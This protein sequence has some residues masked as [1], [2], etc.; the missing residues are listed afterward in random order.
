MTEKSRS[1]RTSG[2]DAH[3]LQPVERTRLADRAHAALRQSIISGVFPMGE[4]LIETQLA[5]QLNMSRA[6]I[7]EALRGL[8]QEGLVVEHPHQGAFVATL[9][10]EDVTDLYN[11]RI[12]IETTA[13]RLFIRRGEST[14]PLREAIRA[15]Q[16]AAERGDVARVAEAEFG[17]HRTI[18]TGCGNPL[19]ARLFSEV[20]GR[21]LM[22]IALDD[23][24]FEE[25]REVADEHVPVVEAIEA[26][27]E[28]QAVRVFEEHLVSTVGELLERL[29]G[30]AAGVLRPCERV[31]GRM[32]S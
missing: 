28:A 4:R 10:A 1:A 14:A 26:R 23:A 5:A 3:K 19:L 18:C 24:M 30:D 17:F 6:P 15:M 32:Q 11:V 9:S 20:E 16:R 25:L 7:R 8:A 21:V 12:G 2:G 13:L 22:V 31:D 29:G 27:D